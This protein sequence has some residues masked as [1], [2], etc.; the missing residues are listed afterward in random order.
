MAFL[1]VDQDQTEKIRD[2]LTPKNFTNDTSTTIWTKIG[3]HSNAAPSLR[4]SCG[5][6][7]M[8]GYTLK[9]GTYTATEPNSATTPTYYCPLFSISAEKKKKIFPNQDISSWQLKTSTTL[10]FSLSMHA[11][12]KQPSVSTTTWDNNYT[13]SLIKHSNSTYYL[14]NSHLSSTTSGGTITIP[15]DLY[16]QPAPFISSSFSSDL[17]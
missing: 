6:V 15:F 9:A 5:L 16:L 2:A 8:L 17:I 1:P 3:S 10:A 13:W 11:G 7:Q 4:I 14:C 12:I